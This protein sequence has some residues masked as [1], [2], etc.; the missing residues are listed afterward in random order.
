M[1]NK[2]NRFICL[3]KFRDE[4]LKYRVDG[5]IEY[6]FSVVRIKECIVVW[7]FVYYISDFSGIGLFWYWIVVKL[8]S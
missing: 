4:G 3:S 5:E 2:G 7:R 1:V 6:W 8:D